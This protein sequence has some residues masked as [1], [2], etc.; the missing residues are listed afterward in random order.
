MPHVLILGGGFGGVSTAH[1][2][3]RLLGAE[4]DITLVDRRTHFVMGFRKTM[5]VVGREPLETGMRPLEALASQG[6]RVVR[7]TIES[8]DAAAHA[9]VVD[10]Q[11]I[12]ADA[13]VVAL[14][15]DLV[16]GAIPGLAENAIN[17]YSTDGVGPA[18]DAL[19]SLQSG[20]LLI[21]IFGAPYKCP[22]APYELA[23]LCKDALNAR[24]SSASIT[25]FTPQPGSLPVLGQAGC[26]V[27]EGRLAGQGIG[28][29]AS[30]KIE[31]VEAGRVVLAG[32]GLPLEDDIAFDVLFAVPPHRCPPVVVDAG[33]AQQGGW[34]KINPRTLET[35]H[36]DVYAIGD[37][38]AVMMATGQP[39]PKAGAFAD[40]EGRVVAERLAAKF[41]GKTSDA[42]FDGTGACFL[43]TGSGEAM[44]V[45]GTFLAEPAPDIELTPPSKEHLEEKSVFERERLDAWFGTTR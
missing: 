2:L 12:E 33:L 43:E 26:D 42:Q 24:G 13:L 21:G 15:A 40:N 38:T 41:Q 6:V 44:V 30:T 7:G 28:F 11:R 3:H 32:G 35:N 45:R 4:V 8:I 20:S 18:A 23:I 37:V 27:I 16:P 19:A 17:V 1:H 34:V 5:A 25:V 31:R 14:G 10:G 39:M 36:E 22:P 29:R 9:A